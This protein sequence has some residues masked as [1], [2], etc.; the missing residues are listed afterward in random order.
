M[1]LDIHTHSTYSDGYSS[2]HDMVKYAKKIGLDGLA[3]TDHD[4][5]KGSLKALQY[6]RDDFLVIPG[7]EM[8]AKEGHVLC[9]GVHEAFERF[10]PAEKLIEQVHELDGL[11]IAAH[12]YDRFRGGVGDLIYE[13]NFDAVELY[14]GHTLSAYKSVDE[15]IRM[16][17]LPVVGGSDA[18]R[19]EDIGTVFIETE[20]DP[21]DSIRRGNVKVTADINKSR[22]ITSFIKSKLL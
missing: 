19:C 16:N 18:H 5:I 3:I 22:I 14:N 1:K 8:T 11:A 9:L 15:I 6:S 21:L 17:K 12:P 13:L 7:V 2:P 4:I 10:T 20:E